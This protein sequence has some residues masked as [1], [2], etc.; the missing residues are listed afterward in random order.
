MELPLKNSLNLTLSCLFNASITH[1]IIL[2][3]LVCLLTFLVFAFN[4]P[5]FAATGN[6]DV[7]RA[8]QNCMGGGK[9]G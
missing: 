9:K 6:N 3:Q 4:T 5:V 2:R 1:G 7:A 8:V